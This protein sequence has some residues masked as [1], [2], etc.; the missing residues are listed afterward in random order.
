[1]SGTARPACPWSAPPAPPVITHSAA[2][3]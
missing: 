3:L 2:D 1:L